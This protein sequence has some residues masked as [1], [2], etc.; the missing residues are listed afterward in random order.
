MLRAPLRY[1]YAA[2]CGFQHL[3]IYP[4]HFIAENKRYLFVFPIQIIKEY[5]VVSLLYSEYA[6]PL[7]SCVCNCVESRGEVFPGYCFR[8]SQGSFVNIAVW[9]GR[10]VT[11]EVYSAYGKCIAGAEY[12]AYIMHASY[13]IHYH[14][15]R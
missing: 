3:L 2:I 11:A 9:W 6:V 12:G 5:T 8:G 14:Y 7:V 13:I 4:G 10:G 1:L 15:D